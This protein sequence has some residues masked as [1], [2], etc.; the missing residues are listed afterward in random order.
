MSNLKSCRKKLQDSNRKEY[1]K[2]QSQKKSDRRSKGRDYW[3][4]L[5]SFRL[6]HFPNLACISLW[7][8]NV[9]SS[10]N[11][12]LTLIPENSAVVSRLLRRGCS[13][14]GLKLY[15]GTVDE[16]IEGAA[17]TNEEDGVILSLPFIFVEFDS[18]LFMD[19]IVPSV[20][21]SSSSSSWLV[22]VGCLSFLE[23]QGLLLIDVVDSM[24]SDSFEWI[25]WCTTSDDCAIEEEQSILLLSI[26]S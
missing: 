23:T 19:W 12:P 3:S 4:L 25:E 11:N 22:I 26:W 20:F 1:K 18:S 15:T 14:S 2:K 9:Y 21:W 13:A 17:F 7:S 10:W 5:P 24:S 16:D 8:I 6:T